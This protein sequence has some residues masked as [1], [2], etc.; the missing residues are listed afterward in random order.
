MESDSHSTN[1]DSSSHDESTTLLGKRK[2]TNVS[3]SDDCEIKIQESCCTNK[4]QKLSDEEA[5]TIT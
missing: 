5:K 4:R 3:S 2:H 1:E